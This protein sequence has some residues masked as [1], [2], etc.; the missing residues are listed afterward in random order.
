MAGRGVA[1]PPVADKT[2][3]V[4]IVQ[5]RDALRARE[6]RLPRPAQDSVVA[7]GGA[8]VVWAHVQ[9]LCLQHGTESLLP[10]QELGVSTIVG[11]CQDDDGPSDAPP[12][13]GT[14]Y[15]LFGVAFRERRREE[16]SK[17]PSF[18]EIGKAWGALPETERAAFKEQAKQHK[19]ATK[20]T[21]DF[22]GALVRQIPTAQTHEASTATRSRGMTEPPHTTNSALRLVGAQVRS[23][24]KKASP[25]KASHA[26]RN[27]DKC[28]PA[29]G[30]SGHGSTLG[31]T[32]GAART[33]VP[34][35]SRSGVLAL[36]NDAKR[37]VPPCV[38]KE[39]AQAAKTARLAKVARN[40]KKEEAKAAAKAK[41][42]EREKAWLAG[43]KRVDGVLE[44]RQREERARLERIAASQAQQK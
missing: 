1:A 9:A 16:H 18:K 3:A 32:A 4:A 37:K 2:A 40:S 39:L 44:A 6:R 21:E 33:L 36:S 25:K 41:D 38:T 12:V 42:E 20:R 43:A 24:P 7:T 29:F 19:N 30:L 13:S 14:G 27:V 31:T 5:L 23:G 34:N 10:S 17:A 8:S 26:W 15:Q 28:R 35:S 22:E 11:A